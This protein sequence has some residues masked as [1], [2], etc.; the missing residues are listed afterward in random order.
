MY[1][2]QTW[3]SNLLERNRGRE[4][5]LTGEIQLSAELAFENIAGCVTHSVGQ[6]E[7]VS[8]KIQVHFA[9]GV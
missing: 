5:I 9:T 2:L 3:P 7:S 6:Y 4:C 1:S 8:I